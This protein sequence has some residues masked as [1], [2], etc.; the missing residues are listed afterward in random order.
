[1][2]NK[3]NEYFDESDIKPRKWLMILL[4]IAALVIIVI[5]LNKAIINHENNKKNKTSIFDSIRETI[6]N[7]DFDKED[8]NNDY[9]FYSGT[10]YY[11]SVK[12]LLDKVI[13]NNKTN[14]RKINVVYNEKNTSDTDEIKN[15]KNSLSEDKSY[16]V[17]VD[18]GDDGYANKITI[19]R[20]KDKES[21]KWFNSSYEI[22]SGTKSGMTVKHVLDNVITNN[23]TNEDIINVTYNGIKTS[24][25]NEI[26]N[27]K[28]NFSDW[29]NYEISF[30]YDE[31]GYINNVNIS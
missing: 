18:Y 26:T 24:D 22:H 31:Y 29:N 8:F 7:N 23:K 15:I 2:D 16:E 28:S 9:E 12:M 27:I 4:I 13:T 1:M 11:S 17:S 14:N 21:A 25:V 3:K 6:K 20:S 5:L 10:K 30:D 19:E